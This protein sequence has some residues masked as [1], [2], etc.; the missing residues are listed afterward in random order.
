[1]KILWELFWAF[2]RVG[3]LTFGGGYTM[4]PILQREACDKKGWVTQEEMIDYYSVSQ[5]APG[6]IAVNTATFI[7]QKVRGTLGGIFSALG[8]VFPSLV[9]IILIAGLI[10][11]FS[12]LAWVRNAFAGIRVCVLVLIFSA[13]L[14]LWKSA[15]KDRWGLILFLVI[16]AGSL[17][18]D[19]SPMWFVLFAAVAGVGITVLQGKRRG[20]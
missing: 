12:D 6:L 15:V 18:T 7:G 19:L 20:A 14:K 10:Q 11:N 5:C 9:I 4:L 17:L 3:V 1:M 13:I 8:M 16:F 2:A